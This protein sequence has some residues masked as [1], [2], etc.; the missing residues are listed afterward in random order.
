MR[1]V[2]SISVL[3][4]CLLAL[5]FLTGG[6]GHA[7]ADTGPFSFTPLVMRATAPGMPSS[8]A[9]LKITN[10]GDQPDRLI[11]AES[12]IAKKVEIHTMEMDEGVMRMRPV[13]GGLIIGAGESVVLA[14]G[15]LHIMLMGLTTE[16]VAG[17]HY[18]VTLIFE[19]AGAITLKATA[20]RPADIGM[21]MT[22]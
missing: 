22:Q 4:Y 18:D 17:S 1:R 19:K 8:A 15:G 13:D 6:F 5:V 9:Y 10:N 3:K 12:A 7:G 20:K 16:L 2:K 21:K 14:P 11:A